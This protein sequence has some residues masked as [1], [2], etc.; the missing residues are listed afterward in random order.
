VNDEVTHA[1]ARLV[2]EWVRP[3]LGPAV[4]VRFG[5]AGDPGLGG[6][7]TV[8]FTLLDIA[9]SPAPRRGAAPAPLQLRARYL[10][11]ALGFD[12]TERAQC[13]AELAFNSGPLVHVELDPVPGPAFWQALGTVARPA[14]IAAV[15]VERARPEHPVARVRE[16]LITYWAPTRPVSGVIVG[17]GSIPIAG[18]LVEVEGLSLTTYSNSRGEFGFRSVPGSD[19]PPTLLVSAKGT[20][21]R[22]RAAEARLLIRVPLP[23]S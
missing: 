10:V 11:S 6:G 13:L 3:A 14:L 9:P 16:P 4:E 22:V 2:E 20:Q 21:L 1:E 5:N 23:E 15:L 17:P 18:A 8:V 19:P 7:K 12:P